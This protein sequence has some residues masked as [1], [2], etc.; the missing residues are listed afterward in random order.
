MFHSTSRGPSHTMRLTA[1]LSALMLAPQAL[2]QR[3]VQINT[4]ANGNNITGD[5]ANEPSFAVNPLNP[6]HMV[7]GWRQFPTINSDARYAGV[8][9]SLDGGLTWMNQGVVPPPPGA[10][11]AQQSDP[12][13]AADA[14]GKFFYNSLLFRGEQLGVV[15]YPSDDG[16]FTWNPPAFIRPS[17]ADKNWYDIDQL[18][19]HHYS[20]WQAPGQFARSTDGGQT[21]SRWSMGASIFAHIGIGPD[22][23]VHVGWWE[24]AD[25]VIMRRSDNAR[26]P[27]AVPTFTPEVAIPF[28]SMPWQ[29]P[30]NPAGGCSQVNI[31]VDHREGPTR[32]WVYVLSSA[33]RQND[34]C[35]VM[36]A[37]STDGGQTFSNPVR[38]ND[39]SSGQDYQWM[40]A[41]SMSPAGRLDAT[42]LDTRDDPNHRD[43]RLYYSYSWDGG[44]TWSPNRPVSDSFNPLL[45]WPVQRKIGDYFQSRSD[46]GSVSVIYPA[47]F[48]GEQ[49]I[50]FQRLH[51]TVLEVS[52]L[53]AG[54]PAQF[55]VSEAWPN[56]RAWL[57][58]S[59]TGPGY[60]NVGALNV[61]VNLARPQL[62]LG[63]RTADAFGNVSFTATIP[64][65][66]RGRRVWFQAI[67]RENASNVVE[68]VVQ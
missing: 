26:D 53:I 55:D 38:V 14:A 49:D 45:G 32:G 6:L 57:V 24:G 3:G 18:G 31:A 12:V 58:Y 19:G 60:V 47:T 37:R 54:Q 23:E 43:S 21:W 44:V 7:V 1:I 61:P 36:F 27:G 30:V 64:P 67:Q 34:V 68:D 10:P 9:V 52:P 2:A 13:L 17:S 39:D 40:A 66:S 42:W 29:P 25:G 62:G 28:G 59:T 20:I 22:G 50:Y 48:N 46:N 4:D 35:D 65:Q 11:S 5:A 15:V 16:G 63:P 41:M 56:E 33:V 8:A 51:P